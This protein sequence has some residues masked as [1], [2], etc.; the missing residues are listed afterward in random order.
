MLYTYSTLYIKD[1]LMKRIF[2]AV[3]IGVSVTFLTGCVTETSYSPGYN[4]SYISST[5]YGVGDYGLGYG[6]NYGQGVAG[7]GGGY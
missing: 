5:G 6:T 3:L 2:L 7:F 4:T 1:V